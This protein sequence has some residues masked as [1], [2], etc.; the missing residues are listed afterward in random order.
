MLNSNQIRKQFLTDVCIERILPPPLPAQRR[1]END[2][3]MN[4]EWDVGEGMGETVLD[5][6]EEVPDVKAGLV[7]VALPPVKTQGDDLWG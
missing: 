4:G 1:P 6:R 3:G 5:E 2:G 7:R